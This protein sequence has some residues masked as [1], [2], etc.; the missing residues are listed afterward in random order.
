MAFLW[1]WSG[2]EAAL[3]G[4]NVVA[5]GHQ[6]DLDVQGDGLTGGPIE[7]GEAEG[8]GLAHQYD[9]LSEEE[10]QELLSELLDEELLSQDDEDDQLSLAPPPPEEPPPPE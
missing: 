4:R 5:E 9:P 6:G 2:A 7:P 8:A 1:L 3:E 10:E